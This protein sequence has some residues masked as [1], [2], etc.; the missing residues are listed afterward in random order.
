MLHPTQIHRFIEGLA[1]HCEADSAYSN[2]SLTQAA[3]PLQAQARN[4]N[5]SNLPKRLVYRGLVLQLGPSPA[6]QAQ[7]SLDSAAMQNRLLLRISVLKL[8]AENALEVMAAALGANNQLLSSPYGALGFAMQDNPPELICV[9]HYSQQL[10]SIP[11][12]LNTLDGLIALKQQYQLN[13]ECA[14]P[15]AL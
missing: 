10:P 12:F 14:I 6:Q 13:A 4:S 7:P 11:D 5:G 8:T 2:H 9:A 15:A 3:V 1:K